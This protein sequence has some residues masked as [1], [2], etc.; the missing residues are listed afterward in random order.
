VSFL[1]SK[2]AML[3]T[4]VLLMQAGVY[5]VAAARSEL[6]PVVAPLDRFPTTIGD[7]HMTA[8]YPLTEDTQRVLRADD[9]LNRDYYNPAL[10]KKANLWVAFYMT[11]RYGQTP[12]SPKACLPGAGW[13]PVENGTI[14]I[15]VPNWPEPI[16]ANK[17]VVAGADESKELVIYWYQSHNRVIASEYS[18]RFWLVLDSMRYRRSDTSLVRAMAAVEHDN[19]DAATNTAVAFIK[20]AFPALLLQLPN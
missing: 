15:T 17:Y 8:N 1:K 7:W 3:L 12:H 11:Q 4:I 10:D 14:S 6:T 18:A 5:Y 20:A 13:E 9:T 19:V 16:V 2:Y